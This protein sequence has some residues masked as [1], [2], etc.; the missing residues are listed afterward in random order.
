MEGCCGE[1]NGKGDEYPV[2]CLTMPEKEAYCHAQ[3]GELM[4]A[5][6]F[7]YAARFDAQD[8]R[9]DQLVVWEN[10]QRTTFLSGAD[11][12]TDSACLIFLVMFGNRCVMLTM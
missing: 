8:A 4:T 1:M 12:K 11:I 7:E 3:G 2:V 5:A 9:T 10:G 6:Q